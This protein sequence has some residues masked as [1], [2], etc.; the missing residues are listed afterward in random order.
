LFFHEVVPDSDD[1]EGE[2]QIESA[3]VETPAI[4]EK[5]RDEAGMTADSA[6]PETTTAF[7][8]PTAAHLVGDGEDPNR[9]G[10]SDKGSDTP[11]SDDED[12]GSEDFDPEGMSGLLPLTIKHWASSEKFTVMVC[13]GMTIQQVKCVVAAHSKIAPSQFALLFGN[14]ELSASDMLDSFYRDET[15]F[16]LMKMNGIKG[17]ASKRKKIEDDSTTKKTERLAVLHLRVQDILTQSSKVKLDALDSLLAKVRDDIKGLRFDPSD[18]L[19]NPFH[20]YLGKVP[21]SRVVQ[22]LL[23]GNSTNNSNRVSFLC[24]ELLSDSAT[25]L[26][27]TI[28]SLDTTITALVNALECPI[29]FHFHTSS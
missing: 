19:K 24:R 25:E 23:K 2:L 18:P 9:N 1:S 3:P 14:V 10:G 26:R 11:Q 21:K 20:T 29:P 16:L 27:E 5:D 6:C 7:V 22:A 28:A 15:S 17:G 8:R 13:N 4:L 12:F